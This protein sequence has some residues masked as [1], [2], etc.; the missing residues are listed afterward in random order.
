MRINIFLETNRL[1]EIVDAVNTVEVLTG[2][3][4]NLI[5]DNS[6]V[7]SYELFVPDEGRHVAVDMLLHLL[8]HHRIDFHI[9]F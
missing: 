5:S 2:A 7:S 1:E 9:T 6:F 4:A 8:C 3:E